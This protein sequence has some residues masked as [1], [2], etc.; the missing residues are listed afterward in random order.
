MTD[1]ITRLAERVEAISTGLTEAERRVKTA[2][3]AAD[4]RT[5]AKQQSA[6]NLVPGVM[7]CAKC[8]FRLHRVALYM[9]DGTTGAGDSKTEPCPNGCGPLWPVTWEQEAREAMA[10][11]NSMHEQLQAAQQQGK[12]GG[13]AEKYDDVLLPFVALM[14]AELH[15]N[16]GKGDRPGWLRMSTDTC[17]LEIY[18][19]LAKLQKAVRKE[20]G[21]AICEHAADVANMAMMLVDICG[22][23]EVHDTPPANPPEAG[24]TD[25]MVERACAAHD[26][27]YDHCGGDTRA[28][29]REDMRRALTAA[30]APQPKDA[31]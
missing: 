8:E 5:L 26:R 24:V 2:G 27:M 25:A 6:A 3:I 10:L 30:L 21:N 14:R 29:M 31:T 18:Y 1:D 28:S 4:L 12:A 13:V 19:H 9:G 16:S 15:A 7:H 23:L 17:L 11:A 20:A 22:G